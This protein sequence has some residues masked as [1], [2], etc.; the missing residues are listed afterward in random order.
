MKLENDFTMM[1]TLCLHVHYYWV[2]SY[3]LFLYALVHIHYIV[4]RRIIMQ[5]EVL[6]V[7]VNNTALSLSD[8][9]IMGLAIKIDDIGHR[10]SSDREI[11]IS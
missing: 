5:H 11:F 3:T 10:A 2:A 4:L 9:M 7:I 6:P 1:A 8:S